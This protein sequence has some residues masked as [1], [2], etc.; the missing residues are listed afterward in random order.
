MATGGIFTL[1]TNDGKQDRMLMASELLRNR[2]D[3]VAMARASNPA[4]NDPTPTL[5]DIEK[6]HILFTN[7]H[8]K[9]FAAVGFEY[10]KTTASSGNASLG[11]DVT[12]SI[13]QFGDFFHDMVLYVKLKQPTLTLTASDVSDQPL[14]RWCPFPGERLLEQVE[15]E[16]NGNPLD[17]YF[18]HA[19]N[20]HR[21]FN[22]QPNKRLGWDRCVG[23][24]EPEQGF[25][26]Q[27]NWAKSGVAPSG[28]THR[29][30]S[31]AF[32]GDRIVCCC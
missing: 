18:D 24:E 17:K 22:V 1:I 9:P 26:D 6:T 31:R 30:A 16:V 14:M 2:L 12:F 32:S 21:E 13:P 29:F 15:F 19:V 27:P 28:V 10:N 4:I 7:A 5:L 8:F 20:F 3:A 23:Q 11:N 25:L